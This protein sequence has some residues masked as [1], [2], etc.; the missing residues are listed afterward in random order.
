MKQTLL[1]FLTAIFCISCKKETAGLDV[2]EKGD[3]INVLTDIHLAEGYLTS[4]YG[5]YIQIAA[6]DIYSA[7]YKKH[8]TDSATVRKSIEYYAMHPDQMKS[9]YDEVQKRLQ[10]LEK[11]ESMRVA[12][13]L[14]IEERKNQRVA[15]SLRVLDEIRRD[16]IEK[17]YIRIP[18]SQL[19]SPVPV[20]PLSDY[21]A[22][23]IKRS[24]SGPKASDN[25]PR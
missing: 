25:L 9:I 5:D 13:R 15:D 14:K 12:E 10:N 7:V 2:I 17:R 11:K 18:S 6:K 8:H 21:K 1:L 3:M 20:N 24:L 19:L 23:S 22:D 4:A 16:S